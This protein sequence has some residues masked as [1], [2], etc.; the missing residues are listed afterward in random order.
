MVTSGRR[1]TGVGGAK[2]ARH[3]FVVKVGDLQKGEK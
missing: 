3:A 1:V 2:C